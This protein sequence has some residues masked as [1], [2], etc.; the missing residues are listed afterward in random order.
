MIQVGDTFDG[1]DEHGHL[2]VVLSMPSADDRIVV[3]NLTSHYPERSRQ[4]VGCVVIRPEEHPWVRRLS[5]IFYQRANFVRYSMLDEGL[6]NNEV[7]GHPRCSSGLLRRIQEGALAAEEVADNVKAAIR[8]S[9]LSDSE[10]T[11]P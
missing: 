10:S 3:A 1:F 8:A 7:Q 2:Y 11:D 9:L 4:H 6:R 5:C